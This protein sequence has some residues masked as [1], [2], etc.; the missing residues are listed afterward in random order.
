ML[1]ELK[2]NREADKKSRDAHFFSEI[3]RLVREVHGFDAIAVSIGPGMFTSL[4]VGLSLAKGFAIARGT[5]VV[6]VN[7]LDVIGIPLGF[8]N[9]HVLAVINAYHDEIYAALYSNGERLSDYLLTTPEKIGD[10]I[11]GTTYIVGSGVSVIKEGRTAFKRSE[12]IFVDDTFLL[13]DASK[14]VALALPRIEDGRFDD[15]ERLEPFYIKKTDAEKHYDTT[16]QV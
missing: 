15:P 5:P 3:Q 10:L 8:V 7:T 11:H 13:P 12:V 2:K 1:F 16:H 4:R 14:T 6:A 9:H